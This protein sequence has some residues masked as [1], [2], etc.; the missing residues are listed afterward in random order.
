MAL[1]LGR[2]AYSQR[3]GRIVP[4][5]MPNIILIDSDIKSANYLAFTQRLKRRSTLQEKVTWD[6]DE[7]APIT[8]TTSAAVSSTTQTTIPVSNPT[9]FIPGETWQNQRTDEIFQ[10]TEVNVGTANVTVVRAI[11]ALN[12]SGGT[13]A[14][15]MNSGDQ[16]NRLASLVGEN[17]SRQVT[18]T[19]NHTEVFNYCQQMRKDL[20]LSMRQQKRQF[21]NENEM[22]REQA[23]MIKEF[24][25]DIDRNQLFSEK[26]R[27]TDSNGDDVTV[28]GG[29]RPFISTN[30]ID[31]GGTLFKS[32]FAEFLVEEGLRYGSSNKVL[33]ASTDV[34]LAFTQ[35][36]DS[37]ST[38]EINVSGDKGITIGTTVM[39]YLAPNGH[40][41]LI[42]E[43]RN[44]SLQRPGEAYGVD[45]TQME[46][47]E[48]TNNG[49][50]GAMQ[51]MKG[52]QDPDDLG[53]VDTLVGDSTITYGFEKAHF[54]MK[55]VD[56]GS[57]SVPN[58]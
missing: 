33:F 47:R 56:G 35:M 32:T 55:N 53:N 4:N 9:Y 38:H 3:S 16:L 46:I 6:T 21:L 29:I 13:S 52:T 23:K 42:V 48:F 18:R 43:D 37:I 7:F 22:P 57:F 2:R 12:S 24:R 45:M 20:S 54:I 50:S 34:I 40:E 25:M 14:A 30:S 26:A 39:K 28:S 58:V 11:T 49:I 5:V 27:Y 17:S 41:L 19:T 1:G 51:L 36:T 8:D 15:A 31:V 10:V 44:I